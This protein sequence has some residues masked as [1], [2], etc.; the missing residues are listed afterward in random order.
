[1]RKLYLS[2]K[3]AKLL[4]YTQLVQL[5]SVCHQNFHFAKQ[6]NRFIDNASP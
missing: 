2:V 5:A 1:V 4:T 6:W 3:T